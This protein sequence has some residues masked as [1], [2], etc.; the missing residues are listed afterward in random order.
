M[1]AALVGGHTGRMRVIVSPGQG[2]QKPGFLSPWLDDP[3]TR[4]TLSRWSELIELDLIAHGSESDAETIKDTRI[5]QPLIVAAGLI[6]GRAV[7]DRL[8]GLPAHYAGHS[9]GEFTAAALAGV[10]S[11]EEALT[12]VARRGAAMAKAASAIPTG[13]VA[14]V[15]LDV[16]SLRHPLEEMGLFTA[17]VNSSSQVVAAGELSALDALKNDPPAGTRVIALE[18]AGAFHTH[19]MDSAR[20]EL[21]RAAA[22]LSPTDPH[23][24]LYTNHDGRIV[25]SGREYLDLLVSQ[26]TSPVRWDRCMDAFMA[27]G[28]QEIVELAPS[29]ALAGLAKRALPGVTIRR[30]DLPTDLDELNN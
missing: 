30:I 2:S 11:D 3:D 26:T 29:G 21:E 4:S 24:V 20:E 28:A 18:V 19:Y 10:I 23:S 16:E 15:G 5:A 17:N 1:E 8:S 22:E 13:M 12:L 7:Q 25:E 6:A 9:V 27:A 14:V